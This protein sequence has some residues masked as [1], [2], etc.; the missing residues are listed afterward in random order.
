VE[1][2]HRQDRLALALR[3]Q[4]RGSALALRAVPVPAAVVAM[5]FALAALTAQQRG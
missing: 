4:P 1:V 3:P 5:L 2:G